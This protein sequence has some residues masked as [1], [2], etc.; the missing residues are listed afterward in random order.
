MSGR[1][2]LDF[3]LLCDP[4]DDGFIQYLLRV[5]QNINQQDAP[6]FFK[7]I[8]SHFSNNIPIDIG[9]AIMMVIRV[10]IRSE[11]IR[12]IFVTQ[13]FAE[14]IPFKNKNY[15]DESFC[16]LNEIVKNCP[17]AFD[18]ELTNKF[19]SILTHSPSKSL[20]ILCSY[21]KQ[22]NDLNTD[23]P[24]P[25][26]DILIQASKYFSRPNLLPSYSSI[27]LHLCSKYPD[28]CSARG[29]Y[30]WD[31]FKSIIESESDVTSLD[32]CYNSLAALFDFYKE[33]E[34]P[35]N[36][37]KIHLKNSEISDSVLSF[38]AVLANGNAGTNED[39]DANSSSVFSDPGILK[40]LLSIS[41]TNVKATLVLMKASSDIQ[42]ASNILGKGEWMV[43]SLPLATDT[44]RL[45]LV[46]FGHQK[47]RSK[48]VSLPTFVPFLKAMTAINNSGVVTIICTILRRVTINQ[49]MLDNMS[50]ECFLDNYFQT[51]IHLGDQVSLHSF[52]LLLDTLSK[53]GF[54]SEFVGAC[55]KLVYLVKND[56]HL[57]QIASYVAANLCK[58]EECAMKMKSLKLDEY[59]SDHLDDPQISKGGQKFLRA[60]QKL[61][62]Q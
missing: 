53:V 31:I 47:L 13:G 17:E 56:K 55:E 9:N 28:Y 23:N 51:A 20:S 21:A 46:I 8:L 12:D 27:L 57:N 52:L 34:I 41:K 7:I 60:L 14:Q 24:W 40:S 49:E 42:I 39:L 50:S 1:Q 16:I 29:G 10:L 54:T 6:K 25:M 2:S 37:I 4:Y 15:V 32:V 3:K 22:F 58:Y 30:C 36:S 44:L 59:F 11:K 61:N 38:L 18:E 48:I 19:A 45:F 26:I 35:I 62:I 5:P 33:G 43:S